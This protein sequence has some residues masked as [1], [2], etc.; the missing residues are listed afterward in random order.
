MATL[1]ENAPQT[2]RRSW[3]KRRMPKTLFGRALAIFLTPLILMQAISTFV[4]YDRHWD[5]MVRRLATSLAGDIALIVTEIEADSSPASLARIDRLSRN[6][7]GLIVTYRSG[8]IL[9]NRGT[10]TIFD[11]TLRQMRHA[12]TEQVRRPFMIDTEAG[13]RQIAITVQISDGVLEVL[14][15][16]KR[17]YTSTTYIF[18]MWMLGSALILFAIALIF[19]R[20]QIRPIRRLAIAARA[21]GLGRE[22]TN[23]KPE[24]AHEVRQAAEAFQQMRAR[25]RRQIKQRTD[26]LSGVSHDLRTPLTRM[27]LQLAMLG[28]DKA[29]QELQADVQDMERMVEGYLAFARGEGTEAAVTTDVKALVADFAIGERRGGMTLELEMIG[30]KL[31]P[32]E[33]KPQSLKRALTNLVSNARRYAKTVRI[34][35]D[36]SDVAYEIFVDDDGPG[37]PEAERGRVFKPFYR[38]DPSRNPETG[39]TGLGLTIARDIVHSHGGE[40]GLEESPL[41]GLRVRIR[42]PV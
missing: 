5:T 22:V 18:V 28:E 6:H 13:D 17:L 33:M 12:M 20:N 11:P 2:K 26:M 31:P 21:F 15:H 27:K 16:E 3:L 41:G 4:F 1:A 36:A 42:M 23:F 37:I 9:E 7:L 25:I 24:G 30:K 34:T 38:G 39:G 10:V 19:M 14:A 8:A 32:V 29:V 35:L 40:I